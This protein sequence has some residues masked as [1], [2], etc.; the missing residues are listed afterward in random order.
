MPTDVTKYAV[1][2]PRHKIAPGIETAVEFLRAEE[3][4]PRVVC[5]ILTDFSRNGLK[6]NSATRLDDCE[7]VTARMFQLGGKFELLLDGSIRW[8]RDEE[9]GTFAIGCEFNEEVTWEV[10]G[11]LFLNGVLAIDATP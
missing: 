6:V 8:Q 5:G 3:K 10:L 1:R 2:N 9:D 7:P 4:Q 11:E